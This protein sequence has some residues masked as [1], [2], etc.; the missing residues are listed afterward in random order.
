MGAMVRIFLR[1]ERWKAP[2]N[3]AKP[4]EIVHSIFLQMKLYE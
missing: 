4:S 1:G 2:F 3:E